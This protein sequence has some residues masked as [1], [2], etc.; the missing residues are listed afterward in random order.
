MMM[1]ALMTF[2]TAHAS[3]IEVFSVRSR[4]VFLNG[5]PAKVCLLDALDDLTVRLN[6]TLAASTGDVAALLHEVDSTPF[7]EAFECQFQAMS[8]ELKGLPAIVFDGK[9]VVYGYQSI[10]EAQALKERHHG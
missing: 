1:T 7:Q 2:K 3:S 4:P 6:K 9:E 10:D 5:H 8:Y